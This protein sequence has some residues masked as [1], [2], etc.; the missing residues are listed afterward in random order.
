MEELL[1]MYLRLRIN[2]ELE[3]INDSRRAEKYTDLKL[4]NNDIS[5]IIAYAIDYIENKEFKEWLVYE[6][7]KAGEEGNIVEG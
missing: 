3:K 7:I 4:T 6:I 2:K 1:K 5:K